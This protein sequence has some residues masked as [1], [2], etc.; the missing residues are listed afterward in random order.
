[1]NVEQ[2]VIRTLRTTLNLQ[3][4]AAELNADTALLGSMAELDS[5]A[6]VAILTAIE[7]RF[8]IVIDDDEVDGRTFASVGSLCAFVRTKLDA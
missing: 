3:G 6:V 7:E 1:V 4:P 8:G 5:M 2:E